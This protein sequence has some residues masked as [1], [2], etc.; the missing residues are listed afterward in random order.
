MIRVKQVSILK[1]ANLSS[2]DLAQLADAM[3]P[4]MFVD[5]EQNRKNRSGHLSVELFESTRPPNL[6]L[7][8]SKTC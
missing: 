6:V 1:C 4:A 5:G 3:E 2:S 7:L 8:Q